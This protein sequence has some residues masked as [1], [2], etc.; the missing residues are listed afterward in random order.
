MIESNN[1]DFVNPLEDIMEFFDEIKA[2]EQKY[3]EEMKEEYDE[4]ESFCNQ[5]LTSEKAPDYSNNLE[6]ENPTES[7][8]D[9]SNNGNMMAH[10]QDKFSTIAL[11]PDSD[12]FA[13]SDTTS[14]TI[15][16]A[17]QNRSEKECDVESNTINA[18]PEILAALPENDSG[19]A[20]RLFARRGKDLLYCP[21]T[22]SSSWQ[23]WNGKYWENDEL[24]KRK[25]LAK[26][27]AEDI[28]Y[29]EA[30]ALTDIPLPGSRVSS[31][32]RHRK[33]GIDSGNSGRIAGTLDLL[34]SKVAVKSEEFDSD[35]YLLNVENGTLNLKTFELQKHDRADRITKIAHVAYDPS[36]TCPRWLQFLSETFPGNTEIID[37]LQEEAGYSLTGDTAYQDNNFTFL[38]GDGE[39]GKS[40]IVETLSVMLGDYATD[41]PLDTW[42]D[43]RPGGATND[44]ARLAGTR[45][46]MTEETGDGKLNEPLIKRV[47]GGGKLTARFLYKEHTTFTPQFKLWITGNKRPTIVGMDHGIWRRVKVVPFEH[48]IEKD[49]IDHYL[50]NK[51]EKELPGILN[52]CLEGLRRIQKNGR[53]SEPKAIQY[54]TEEYKQDSDPLQEFKSSCLIV[55][56]NEKV[57]SSE[58]YKAYCFYCDRM[59]IFSKLSTVKFGPAILEIPGVIKKRVAG[60]QEYHGIGIKDDIRNAMQSSSPFGQMP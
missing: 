12:P 50:K 53:L 41:C 59:H 43:K 60:G 45:F 25:Q 18:S 30:P 5:L 35:P 57:S 42:A 56:Q 14:G 11:N 34:A 46:V 55:D 37:Y 24:G 44:Q 48:Q 8:E 40:V 13:D 31:R 49:K 21:K 39:N 51:L 9:T 54:A 27:N 17:K 19:N 52:W 7:H 26:K 38:Y 23:I 4:E 33:W 58:V 2:A 6:L 32:A 28:Q 15:T 22:A 3:D 16:I 47:T 20:D 10:L 1:N 29:I 36:A